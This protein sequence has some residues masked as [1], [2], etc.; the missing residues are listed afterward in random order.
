MG[1]QPKQRTMAVRAHSLLWSTPLRKR[2]TVALSFVSLL[3]GTIVAVAKA[4]PV[5]EPYAPAHRAYVREQ[6]DD[7]VQIAQSAAKENQAILRDLQ[8]EAAEGKLAA[9]TNDL[10][11][12]NLELNKAADESTKDIIRRQINTLEATKRKLE[13][14]INTLNRIR[15]R[16]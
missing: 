12:W 1:K 5:V 2:L 16:E 8:V 14:Q 15:G 3:A 11:K 9:T 6:H 13:A 7:T 10:A 4:L